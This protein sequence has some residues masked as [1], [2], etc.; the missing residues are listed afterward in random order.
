[1]QVFTPLHLTSTDFIKLAYVTCASD[2]YMTFLRC[3]NVRSK[4]AHANWFV[5]TN[6]SR[7][8]NTSVDAKAKSA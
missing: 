7:V 4:G 6:L 3:Q 5:I 2:T 8:I 1:M